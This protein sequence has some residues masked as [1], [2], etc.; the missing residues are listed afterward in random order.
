METKD[1]KQDNYFHALGLAIHATIQAWE[2]DP[3]D[4]ANDAANDYGDALRQGH[5][6]ASILAMLHDATDASCNPATLPNDNDAQTYATMLLLA[7]QREQ[8]KANEKRLWDGDIIDEED[9][10]TPCE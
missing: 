1:T 2:F 10:D 9:R 3:S 4:S 8:A 7:T 5:G 6:I